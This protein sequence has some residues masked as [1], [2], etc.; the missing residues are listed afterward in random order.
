MAIVNSDFLAGL[1]TNFRAIFQQELGD[2]DTN[3]TLYKEIATIFQST[4]DKETYAWLGSVPAMSEWKD[5]RKLAGMYENDYTLT[6]KDYEATIEVDRNTIEDDKYGLI[7]PRIRGLAL[8]AARFFNEKVFTQLDLGETYKAWD[9]AV[10]FNA[11]RTIGDSGSFSNL[12]SGNYSDSTT[13]ILDG[14]DAAVAAMRKFKDDRGVKMNLIPDCII[15]APE[16]EMMI[17]TAL[18][19]PVA[20][21]VRPELSY[22]PRNRIFVSPFITQNSGKDFYVACTK[23]EVKPVILQMRKEPEID[24]LDD[25]KSEHVFMNRT[26]LYGVNSRFTTGFGDPRT[27]IKLHNT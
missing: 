8:R 20:G 25:P 17:Q 16:R 24:A 5:R 26:F 12:L 15:C 22:F 18:F 10:M 1:L 7:A 4:S 11:A 27:I 23:A 2:L 21:E 19:P 14:L 9:G 3:M 6:N 13:E